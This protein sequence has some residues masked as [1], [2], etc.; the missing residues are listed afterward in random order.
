MDLSK[1]SRIQSENESRYDIE[2]E[3]QLC[4]LRLSNTNNAIVDHSNL[5]SLPDNFDQLKLLI[6]NIIEIL[7]LSENKNWAKHFSHT[8]FL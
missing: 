7:V 1:S 8:D 6:T 4:E 5:K 2:Y 3:R